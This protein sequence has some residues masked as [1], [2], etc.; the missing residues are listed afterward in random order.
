MVSSIPVDI[1]S[2]LSESVTGEI[3]AFDFA[4]GGCINS[5]GRL[6]TGRGDFFLKWNDAKRFPGMFAAEANGLSML[7]APAVIDVPRVITSGISG[8]YQ[9]LLLEYIDTARRSK[10]YWENF[11]KGLAAL[12]KITSPDFGLG[13]NNYM[14][15]LKQINI[16]AL[17]WVDFFIE[18]RLGIQLKVASEN[19]AINTT[20]LKRFDIL[21]GKLKDLLPAEKP[22]LLHG[23]LWSG[24]VMV[25]RK[26]EP[27][28]ID[29]AVYF[30][31]REVDLAMTGLFGG[32]DKSFLKSYH[33][34]FPLLPG[35]AERFDIYNLY[36]L[37]VHVNLF[38]G[39]YLSQVD[40]ILKRFG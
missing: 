33:D 38:G 18:Q 17:S 27:C 23:D 35:Y 11:G 28:L 32:V 21:F 26:G 19:N 37:L 1:V 14:G 36:P 7:R 13:H 9:Y 24:N 40:A 2:A 16:Q 3:I 4:S 8:A 39:G 5:G 25:N 10:N 12:H 6:K 22:S 30:G 34:S 31:N 15:S 29:P 20:V